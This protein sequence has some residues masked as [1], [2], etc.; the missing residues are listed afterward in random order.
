MTAA[1]LAEASPILLTARGLIRSFAAGTSRFSL[2][3]ENVSLQAGD[4]VAVV[5]PSGCGKSTLLGLL[6]LALAPNSQTAS[7]K[8]PCACRP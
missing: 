2:T 7:E 3:V 1:R 6:A 8:S 4:C 5:G